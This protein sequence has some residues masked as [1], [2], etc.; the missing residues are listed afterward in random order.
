MIY[1]SNEAGEATL[2]LTPE[3]HACFKDGQTVS[4]VTGCADGYFRIEVRMVPIA[5]PYGDGAG[6]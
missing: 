6:E 3:E 2:H 4:K 1:G 5:N